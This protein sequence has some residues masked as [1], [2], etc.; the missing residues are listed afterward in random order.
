MNKKVYT[1]VRQN[2]NHRPPHSYFLA[3]GFAGAGFAAAG[4]VAA[5]LA[6]AGL[7]DFLVADF[8][9]F[10]KGFEDLTGGTRDAV[11]LAGR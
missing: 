8:L 11:F 9:D 7:A 6:A 1:V 4:F 2:E 10:F 3:A 5:G